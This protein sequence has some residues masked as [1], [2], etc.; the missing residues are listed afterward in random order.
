MGEAD[1]VVNNLGISN[2]VGGLLGK[3]GGVFIGGFG[4]Q[5]L[6]DSCV[7]GRGIQWAKGHDNVTVFL[8]VGSVEGSLFLI[9][10]IY[11]YLMIAGFG[12]EADE[13]KTATFTVMKNTESVVAAR[14][15]MKERSGDSVQRS[16]VDAEPPN[17]VV[18]IIDVL[19]VRFGGKEA[20]GE[21]GSTKERAD[22]TVVEQRVDVFL[23]NGGFVNSIT[24]LSA[25]NGRGGAGVNA[26]F[27]SK[28]G[29][30]GALGV[31]GIPVRFNDVEKFGFQFGIEIIRYVEVLVKERLV[32][33][34]VPVYQVRARRNV[35]SWGRLA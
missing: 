21:P 3:A 11:G 1:T 32:L 12:V 35:I 25:L 18:N 33:V 14:D 5:D 4:A 2:I 23:D 10:A 15:G 26:E 16:E 19:L 8:E 7:D 6:H 28:H 34:G 24:G 9:R 30:G 17:K 31:E 29:S 13:E 20:F 27:K 22:V